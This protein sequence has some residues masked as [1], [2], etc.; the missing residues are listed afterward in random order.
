MAKRKKVAS[1]SDWKE[2]RKLIV[3]DIGYGVYEYGVRD[4]AVAVYPSNKM[5]EALAHANRLG[6]GYQCSAASLSNTI[7]K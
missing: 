2:E 6:E 7:V 5:N 3:A 4:W 1:V